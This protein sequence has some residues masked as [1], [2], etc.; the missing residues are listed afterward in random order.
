MDLGIIGG[1]GKK[2][3]TRIGVYMKK[4]TI[5]FVLCMIY[6]S[7]GAGA[8]TT[9]RTISPTSSN[10]SAIMSSIGAGITAAIY[11]SVRIE[12]L[13]QDIQAKQKELDE[14][15]KQEEAQNKIKGTP[16]TSSREKNIEV[17]DITFFFA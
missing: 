6:C 9:P 2:F 11:R 5:F 4:S 16:K 3:K 13:T 12:N 7:Y 15:D 14:S 10:D 8:A 17:S 1:C